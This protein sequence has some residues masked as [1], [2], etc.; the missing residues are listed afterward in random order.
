[1]TLS[2]HQARIMLRAVLNNRGTIYAREGRDHGVFAALVR[3]GATRKINGRISKLTVAGLDAMEAWHIAG[4][5][6][7]E[8]GEAVAKARRALEGEA[9]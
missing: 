2:E 6:E 9:K 5:G 3:M 7:W 8:H 1:M 4:P